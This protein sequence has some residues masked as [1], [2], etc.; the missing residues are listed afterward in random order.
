MK[1]KYIV[2][3]PKNNS[4]SFVKIKLYDENIVLKDE[5]F[6]MNKQGVWEINIKTKEKKLVG[7]YI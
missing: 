2:W 1:P 6:Y 4:S 5:S 7:E 3:I